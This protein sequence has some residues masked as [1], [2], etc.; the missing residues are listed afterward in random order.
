MLN[1]K[2]LVHHVNSRILKVNILKQRTLFLSFTV[3]F[4]LDLPNLNHKNTNFEQKFL[5]FGRMLHYT[6]EIACRE[7]FV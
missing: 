1:V 6:Y 3:A 5:L 7:P 2:L 4:A